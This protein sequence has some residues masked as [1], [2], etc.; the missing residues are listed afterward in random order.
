MELIPFHLQLG[1]R[2]QGSFM[3]NIKGRSQ[4][5]GLLD[6]FAEGRLNLADLV[7][8]HLPMSEVNAGFDLMRCGESVRIV[9]F[10]DLCLHYQVHG[11]K[12]SPIANQ[13]ALIITHGANWS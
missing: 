12:T 2:V 8:H 6:H 7:T 1:R 9:V 5:P 10:S 3:S 11:D 13:T 4:L